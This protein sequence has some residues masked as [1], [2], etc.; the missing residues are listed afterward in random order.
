MS[1]KYKADEIDLRKRP[2]EKL[3]N[4]VNKLGDEKVRLRNDKVTLTVKLM[5]LPREKSLPSLDLVI[6]KKEL[7]DLIANLNTAPKQM[8]LVP[9]ELVKTP[10]PNYSSSRARK[11]TKK[12]SQLRSESVINKSMNFEYSSMLGKKVSLDLDQKSVKH[13]GR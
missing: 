13:F 3:L 4:H 2:A 12:K 11:S 1:Q 10:S 6:K 7:S 8:T 9:R 5:R